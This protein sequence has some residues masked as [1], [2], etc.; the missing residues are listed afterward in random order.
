MVVSECPTLKGGA[1][2]KKHHA[3]SG[4]LWVRG[5][6]RFRDGRGTGLIKASE[7]SPM[8]LSSIP[9]CL[10]QDRRFRSFSENE[11]SGCSCDKG[12][13]VLKLGVY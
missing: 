11:G 3:L 8:G 7:M 1:P 12:G 2:Q 13:R 5:V 10:S 9:H 6:G 4:D